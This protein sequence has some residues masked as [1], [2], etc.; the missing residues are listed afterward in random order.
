VTTSTRA[1]NTRELILTAAERLFAEQGLFTVSNRQVSEA[2]G[3]GNNAAVGYHFGTKTDL[4]QAIVQR[5]AAPMER[6]RRDLLDEARDSDD[7]RDWVTVLV[8]PLTVHLATLGSPT[9][10]ARFS[11][12]VMTDPQHR[13]LAVEAA[14]ATEATRTAVEGLRRCSPDLPADVRAER[15]VML[16]QLLS[17]MSAERERSLAESGA[18]PVAAWEST[19]VNLI[20]ALTGMIQ[21]PVTGPHRARGL[22]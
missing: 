19:A 1:E 9:W 3:Q 15:S 14:M 8:R 18:D 2:A 11:A 7:L 4:I 20:D 6:L 13:A 16:R 10:Y 17:H 5:H 12:Q 22:P 21:A